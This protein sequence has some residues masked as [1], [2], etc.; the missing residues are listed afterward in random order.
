MVCPSSSLSIVFMDGPVVQVV[1][2]FGLSTSHQCSRD[3]VQ[4][5][6]TTPGAHGMRWV[7]PEL[8]I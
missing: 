4:T 1:G 8:Q 5:M 2:L 3:T 6:I 7:W